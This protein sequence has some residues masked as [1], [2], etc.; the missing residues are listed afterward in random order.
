MTH[1]SPIEEYFYFQYTFLIALSK[2]CGADN[3]FIYNELP[4][5]WW[6]DMRNFDYRTEEYEHFLKH[7]SNCMLVLWY[8]MYKLFLHYLW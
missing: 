2:K 3:A 1:N 7:L 6:K 4:I 5:I 8:T